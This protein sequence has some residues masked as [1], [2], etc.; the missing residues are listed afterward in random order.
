MMQNIYSLL[1]K[2]SHLVPL[3][4]IAGALDGILDTGMKTVVEKIAE[5]Y[6]EHI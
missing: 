3:P 1:G 6:A 4:P 2:G 5:E